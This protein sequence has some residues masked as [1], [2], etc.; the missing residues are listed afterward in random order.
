MTQFYNAGGVSAVLKTLIRD[1]SLFKDTVGV[2]LLKTSEIVKDAYVDANVIHNYNEPFTTTRSAER[3]P[4]TVRS[5]VAYTFF[6]SSVSPT[7][8]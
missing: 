1:V 7:T 4:R 5:Y 3:S 6:A 2:S 8:I